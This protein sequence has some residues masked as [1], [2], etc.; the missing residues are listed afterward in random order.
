MELSN[1]IFEKDIIAYLIENP[2]H[3]R[4]IAQV[5]TPHVFTNDTLQLS[6]ICCIEL[7]EFKGTFGRSDLFRSLKSK[8]IEKEANQIL[9]ITSDGIIDIQQTMNTLNEMYHKRKLVDTSHK[10]I[11]MISA[12]IDSEGIYYSIEEMI[13]KSDSENFFNQE[14]LD[15]SKIFDEVIE[16]YT[17]YVGKEKISGVTTGSRGLDYVTGGW[18]EG[19]AVIGA[20]PSMGKTIV[21]LDFAKQS[22]KSGVPTL[23]VSLEMNS[24]DLFQRLISSECPEFSY[25][26]L[27]NYRMSREDIDKIQNSKAKELKDLPLY[28]YDSDNRDVNYIVNLITTQARRNKVR[29]VVIDY[30]QL[31]KDSLIKDQSDFAQV[32]SISNKIQKL[33]RKLNIPIIALSQLSR[34]VEGRADKR[35]ML[36]DIRSSGNIE[37]DASIVIGLH[38]PSYY[39][40][41]TEYSELSDDEKHLLEFVVLKNRNGQTGTTKRYVDVKTNRVSDTYDLY[42]FGNEPYKVVFSDS[43]INEIPNEFDTE[44]YEEF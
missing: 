22:A 28:I 40:E 27:M 2:S 25:T 13:N 38:R 20:R 7:F 4:D 23:Y 29:M 1:L 12:G 6:Y 19:L 33:T 16:D 18:K 32:S 8:G 35:P 43:K 44:N 3:T 26:D 36:S 39:T 11:D 10:I 30:L 17:E 15:S 9:T 21:G 31:M 37:Q 24:K 41:D 5:L 42:E 14:V 34:N